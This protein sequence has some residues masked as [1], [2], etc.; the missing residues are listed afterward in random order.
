MKTIKCFLAV[1]RWPGS[2]EA[3]QA[4]GLPPFVSALLSS[5]RRR[6]RLFMSAAFGF[7]LLGRCPLPGM[8]ILALLPAFVL[9]HHKQ[10]K[11][12]CKDRQY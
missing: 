8:G 1:Q 3:A 5:D 12:E 9:G 7:F 11:N 2:P 10:D 6:Q 4:A